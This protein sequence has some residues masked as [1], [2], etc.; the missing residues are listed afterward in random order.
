MNLNFV[1]EVREEL[2]RKLLL[3]DFVIDKTGVKVVEIINASFIA[4]APATFNTPN[5]EYI[6]RELAWYKSMSLNVNDIPPPIPAIWKAVA[7]SDGYINSNYGW[8]IY[9]N[10][11]G[12]QYKNVLETLLKDPYSRRAEMIYTR[13]TMHGAYNAGGMSDF[14][15]TEAVQYF[16]RDNMLEVI[17]KMRSNDAVFGY[18]NDYAWQRHVQ[19]E[20]LEGLNKEGNKYQV[21][22]IHWNAGSFHVYS[23]HFPMIQKWIDETKFK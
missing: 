5:E 8:M 7:T 9:S 1:T 14:V 6:A 13:P 17:V 3:E 12:N 18:A 22:L 15:C 11:N 20:L 4:N 16:I 21:G 19:L 23:R 2:A 10:S